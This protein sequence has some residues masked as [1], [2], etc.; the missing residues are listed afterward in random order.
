VVCRFGHSFLI[1]YL[2]C[3][4]FVLLVQLSLEDASKQLRHDW[5]REALHTWVQRQGWDHVLE[6][7]RSAAANATVVE[8]PASG[9]PGGNLPLAQRA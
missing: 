6:N 3:V 5:M 9:I 4:L 2:C 8:L 1:S 7:L